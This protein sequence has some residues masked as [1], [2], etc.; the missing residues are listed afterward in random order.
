MTSKISIA[1][2]AVAIATTLAAPTIASAQAAIFLPST[3]SLNQVLP[4]GIPA[5][6]RDSVSGPAHHRAP[7]GVK[8]Y[9]QW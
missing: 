2:A 1:A 7:H 4:S 6:A 9:G 5:D 3:Y 8:P